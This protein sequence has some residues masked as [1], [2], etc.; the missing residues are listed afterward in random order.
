M[1]KKE[2]R[3]V[4]GK[5]SLASTCSA[6][7][8]MLFLPN[9]ATSLVL[10]FPWLQQ[11]HDFAISHGSDIFLVLAPPW[12]WHLPGVDISLALAPTWIWYLPGS[13]ISLALVSLWL[14]HL[15]R[16]SISLVLVSP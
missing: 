12:L 9:Y 15:P 8:F 2:V 4:H 11:L 7:S 6:V 10:A 14:W 1:C 16:S 13:C 5:E 3:G